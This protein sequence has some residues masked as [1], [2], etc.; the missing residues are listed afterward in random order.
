ML[1]VPVTDRSVDTRRTKNKC[2]TTSKWITVGLLLAAC[3]AW[4]FKDH[5]V[6]EP[7]AQEAVE[8]IQQMFFGNSEEDD[9]EEAID[10]EEIEK[11]LMDE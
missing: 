5:I 7:V 3:I 1:Y 8:E 11:H 10:V 9:E 6:A 4:S 2:S